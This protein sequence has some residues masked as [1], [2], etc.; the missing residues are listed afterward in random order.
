MKSVPPPENPAGKAAAAQIVEQLQHRLVHGLRVGPS[1]TR[2]SSGRQPIAAQNVKLI[3]RDARVRAPD[4]V[5][6]GIHPARL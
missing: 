4:E 1:E 3:G 5:G 2:M 6:Q